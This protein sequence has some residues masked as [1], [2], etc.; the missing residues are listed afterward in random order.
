MEA[1]A[2]RVDQ[3]RFRQAISHLATGV[4]IITTV[5]EDVPAGMTASAV[6]SLS[7]EPVMLLV[8][9]DNRLQTHAALDGSRRFAVNVLGEHDEWLARRFASRGVDKFAGLDVVTDDGVPVLRAAVATFVCEVVERY[10]GGD[11]SIFLGRVRT[12]EWDS[13]QRPLLYFRSAFGSLED[14]ALRFDRTLRDMPWA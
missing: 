9:V 8:C 14:E 13:A 1:E 11:H 7:M 12:C 3:Q 4:T 10:P 6:C 5:H 2:H